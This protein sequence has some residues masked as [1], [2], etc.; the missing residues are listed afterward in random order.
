MHQTD[1]AAGTPAATAGDL[2]STCTDFD[3]ARESKPQLGQT[4]GDNPTATAGD[5]AG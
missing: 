1:K 3:A 4:A 5:H 2:S